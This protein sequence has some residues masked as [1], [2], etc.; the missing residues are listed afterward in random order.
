MFAW[1]SAFLDHRSQQIIINK[2]LFNSIHITSGVPQG[3]I[4]GPTLFL[5][6]INDL[7][8]A[9]KNLKCVVRV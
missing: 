3:S 4:L 2:C 5:L 1:I 7:T 8:N 6:H 9:F